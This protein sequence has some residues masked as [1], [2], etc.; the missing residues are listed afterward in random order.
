[1]IALAL[2]VAAVG[3]APAANQRKWPTSFPQVAQGEIVIRPTGLRRAV[4]APKPVPTS[5]EADD[6]PR[7]VTIGYLL[8][9]PSE[10]GRGP[11]IHYPIGFCAYPVYPRYAGDYCSYSGGYGYFN[12]AY[13]DCGRPR[14]R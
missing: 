7:V 13:S 6:P 3:G 11:Q 2:C 9:D 4:P 1:M 12:H 5:A 8:R 14:W 10:M